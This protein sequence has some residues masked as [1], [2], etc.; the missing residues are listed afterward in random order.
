VGYLDGALVLGY[1]HYSTTRKIWFGGL[2]PL[3]R[4]AKGSHN[5]FE[6][7]LH[8]KGGCQ[9]PVNGTHLGPYASLDFLY[10]YEGSFNENGAN[11]LNLNIA[12]KHPMLLQSEVGL[13]FS[14][15]INLRKQTLIPFVHV[16]GIWEKRFNGEKEFCH[17]GKCLLDVRGYYPSRVLVGTGGGFTIE[18]A[19]KFA[20]KVSFS[21][22]G[23]FGRGYQD[24]SLNFE[25]IY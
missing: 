8:L 9:L 21:Y 14:H 6:S 17:F 1:D 19:K 13:D 22:Q 23:K 4:R 15:C 11:S 7:S 18:W 20:P 25:L 3:N 5:G 10:I 12:S 2:L 16:S 24:Q